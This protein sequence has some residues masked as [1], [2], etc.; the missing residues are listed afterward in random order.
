MLLIIGNISK[1]VNG[2]NKA[3]SKIVIN[4]KMMLKGMKLQS[5]GVVAVGFCEFLLRG[6]H[7][8]LN[9]TPRC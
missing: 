2:H 1:I 7:I 3:A 9:T 6:S 5:V 4:V 8:K